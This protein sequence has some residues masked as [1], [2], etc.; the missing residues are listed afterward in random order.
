MRQQLLELYNPL[1]RG[2]LDSE[3]YFENTEDII[4][5]EDREDSGEVSL[6]EINEQDSNMEQSTMK[7]DR[8][9]D[10]VIKPAPI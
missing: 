9:K 5:E 10:M 7:A 6:A 2:L 1:Y 3:A 8:L 4:E